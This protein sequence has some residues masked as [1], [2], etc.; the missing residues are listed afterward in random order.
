[1]L[2]HPLFQLKHC[3]FILVSSKV[4]NLFTLKVLHLKKGFKRVGERALFAI[5]S[6][7]AIASPR[8]KEGFP[9]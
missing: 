3:N 1:M 7:L 2:S 9:T 8:E 4:E 6:L 5:A